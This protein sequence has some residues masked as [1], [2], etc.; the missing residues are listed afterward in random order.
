MK[1]LIV[2][3]SLLIVTLGVS[4]YVFA[5]TL[6]K[7]ENCTLKVAEDF[8]DSNNIYR[9]TLRNEKIIVK[10]EF[11]GG[12]FFDEFALFAIPKL[13]NISGHT[14]NV[15]YQVTFFDKTGE[16]V[17]IAQQ[18]GDLKADAVD[19]QFGSAMTTIS[20]EDFEKIASYKVV[21]TT[22]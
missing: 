21:V 7:G 5:T 9:T 10:C 13:T 22:D 4:L 14:L 8:F 18:K 17:T 20:H 11:S 6:E 2:S 3:I 19:W 1:K 15:S 16:I 12:E